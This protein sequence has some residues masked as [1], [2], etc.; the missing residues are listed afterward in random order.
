[1]TAFT[2]PVMKLLLLLILITN[3]LPACKSPKQ[4]DISGEWH[5]ELDP[6]NQ[7]VEELWYRH[8][9]NKTTQLPNALATDTNNYQGAAWFQ[10]RINIPSSWRNQHIE[11]KL[12]R[13]LCET[14]IWI[15]DTYLGKQNSRATAHCYDLS[16]VLKTGKN[17]LTI[18][19]NNKIQ[20]LTPN[21]INKNKTWHN[22][23]GE[24][25]LKA[26]TPIHINT[27]VLYPNI[28]EKSVF[29]SVEILNENNTINNTIILHLNAKNVQTG[30]ELPR[31]SREIE[32]HRQATVNVAYPMG[33][34]PKPWNE[35]SPNLYTMEVSIEDKKTLESKEIIFGMIETQLIDNKIFINGKETL[36]KGTKDDEILAHTDYSTNQSKDWLKIFNSVKS[37]GYNYINFQTNCPPKAAFDAADKVGLYLQV[38]NSVLKAITED[39][40][41][42][43]WMFKETA[44]IIK[45]Y[46]NH[47]S[48]VIMSPA[49]QTEVKH[50]SYLR[51]QINYWKTKNSR[52]LYIPNYQILTITNTP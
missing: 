8:E 15:N 45:D 33:N 14:E 25:S 9:F 48:F 18:R 34:A 30:E 7:G 29:T 1:M 5:Y 11:L 28:K 38:G 41:T 46:S 44:N 26:S 51:K 24:M 31:V 36:L 50:S 17:K 20:I 12:E 6:K 13:C 19:E 22:I 43:Q 21:V 27:I 47:P 42:D 3:L 23:T 10:K 37:K 49:Y 32:F 52:L 39:E 16:G 4:I 35:F 2:V 40:T